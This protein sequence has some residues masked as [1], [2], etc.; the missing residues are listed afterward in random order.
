MIHGGLRYLRHLEF[1][2]AWESAQERHTLL[3]TTAPHL[4]RELPFMIPLNDACPPKLGVAS[5]AGIRAGDVLRRA[6][7]S[8]RQEL[9][10]AR[11]VSRP[12]A[13]R[14][15]PAVDRP[16]LR[17]AIVFW[18]GQVEDDARLVIGIA[19]TAALYGARILTYC[20]AE[21][22]A[23]G[24]V[25]AKDEISGQQFSIKTRMIIN[26]AGVWAGAL[27]P[28]VVLQPS[29]GTHLIVRSEALGSPRAAVLTP[30]EGESARWVGATPA[31]DSRIIIGVTDDPYRGVVADEPEA[32]DA[33]ERFLLSTL[34]QALN[35]PLTSDA[36]IGRFSGFRPLVS[37]A[38]GSTA[39]LSRHD[40]IGDNTDM[41]LTT[42]VGGKLTTYRA[43]AQKVLDHL[44]A[45][46]GETRPCRTANLPLVG[47]A[48]RSVLARLRAPERL[49]RRYGV[50]AIDVAALGNDHPELLEALADSVPALGVELVFGLLH[51]GA[52]SV[53]DLLDR[54]LRLGLVPAERE[55]ALTAAQALFAEVA[56]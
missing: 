24:R 1:G 27:D 41:G 44:L 3:N 17:G 15:A 12:E 55:A 32:T 28:Q 54:R 34:S 53:D 45:T 39:D 43:M 47:A 52:L 38:T 29:K 11:R 22:T 4:V 50:E 40:H 6:S 30:V 25:A 7:G 49:V 37:G 18:D 31:S 51:E 23:P 10:R 20:A 48:S 46:R 26:A 36:V 21:S 33:E 8:R 19:R 42:I 9:P 2:V 16:D 13:L 35:Q 14:L 5:E 56:A